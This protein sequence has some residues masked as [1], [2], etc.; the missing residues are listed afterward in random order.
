VVNFGTAEPLSGCGSLELLS[1]DNSDDRQLPI[2]P[3]P[4]TVHM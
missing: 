4:D 3:P 1:I 2:Y